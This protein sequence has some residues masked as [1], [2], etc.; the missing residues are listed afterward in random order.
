MGAAP[1]ICR[2]SSVP[3]K[4]IQDGTL[5]V[6]LS[7]LGTGNDVDLHMRGPGFDAEAGRIGLADVQNG[8]GPELI[9]KSAFGRTTLGVYYNWVAAMGAARGEL[10]VW[11][12]KN[13][14]P[15]I[16]PFALP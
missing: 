14:E 12:Y 8:L 13:R 3:A 16:I 11:D 7:W 2:C 1:Y 5:S 15:Y 10:V 9:R 6:V 4:E